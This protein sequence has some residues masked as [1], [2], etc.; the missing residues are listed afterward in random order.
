ML[1]ALLTRVRIEGTENIPDAGP[2]IVA[3]NHFHFVDPLAV[4]RAMPWP[5]DFIGG[6]HMPFAPAIVRWLPRLWGLYRVRRSGSSR[7]ALRQAEE[8]LSAGG[9]LGIF[10]EG[11]SW[12]TVLRPPRPGSA[13]LATRTQ[14]QVLP[15]GLHGLPEIFSSLRRLRRATITIRIGKPIG[16]FTASARG[17][18]GRA[19]LDNVGE[20]ILRAIAELIPPDGR[21]VYSDNEKI[22]REDQAVAQ[23]PWEEGR[24]APRKTRKEQHEPNSSDSK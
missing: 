17:R 14:A 16:P 12:A 18:A 2:L 15:V 22:R 5:L 4:I 24:F 6:F 21:G 1:F 19:E 3:A 8:T 7:G 9:I 11:G 23:Y 20:T 10:P 13:F